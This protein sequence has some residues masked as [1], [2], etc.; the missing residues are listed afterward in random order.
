MASKRRNM[1]HKNKKQETMENGNRLKRRYCLQSNACAK[2]RSHKLQL[3]GCF[4]SLVA[5]CMLMHIISLCSSWHYDPEITA[6]E[7][8]DY[9]NTLSYN[10]SVIHESDNP[11]TTGCFAQPVELAMTLY[12]VGSHLESNIPNGS[13]S[14]SQGAAHFVAVYSRHCPTA[15]LREL[16]RVYIPLHDGPR[17]I[18]ITLGILPTIDASSAFP[19]PYDSEITFKKIETTLRSLRKSTSKS[20][21]KGESE[22]ALESGECALESGE[23]AL[24]SG[25]VALDSGGVALESGE[26]A[27]DSGGVALE[28]GEC[29][30]DSGGVAL[31]SG[32]RRGGMR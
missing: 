11:T 2:L 29:A 12:F 13:P 10:S 3:R 15:T 9:R 28:S 32:A 31:E 30:L 24:D 19:T 4:F 5:L 8:M 21:L 1:F 14:L 22:C 27:L 6:E 20:P 25:G 16:F 18:S 26:C 17:P 23:C 7:A